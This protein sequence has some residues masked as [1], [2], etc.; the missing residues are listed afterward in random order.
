LKINLE[1]ASW[2]FCDCSARAAVF[3]DPPCL[4]FMLGDKRGSSGVAHLCGATTSAAPSVAVFDANQAR[5]NSNHISTRCSFFSPHFGEIEWGL[6][7][8]V[9]H[10]GLADTPSLE[11]REGWCNL[12][13]LVC[14]K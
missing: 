9:P 2:W 8:L 6:T 5:E 12:F 3:S 7:L 14:Y 10:D 11:N 1:M 13:K 4:S